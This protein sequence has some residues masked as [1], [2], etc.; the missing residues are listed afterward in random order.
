MSEIKTKY[1]EWVNSLLGWDNQALEF[2]V[3]TGQRN[4]S[5]WV[6]YQQIEIYRNWGT[7]N[8]MRLATITRTITTGTDWKVSNIE[9]VVQSGEGSPE[10]TVYGLKGMRYIDR[11]TGVVYYKKSSTLSNTGWGV[12]SDA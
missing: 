4:G 12:S 1:Q 8:Y 6:T 11:N 5:G 7:I 9:Y 3:E 10:G 2:I